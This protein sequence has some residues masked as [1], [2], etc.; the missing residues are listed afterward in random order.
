VGPPRLPRAAAMTHKIE[1]GGS[2]RESRERGHLRTAP[3]H[4]IDWTF[5]RFALV[6][7]AVMVAVA[8]IGARR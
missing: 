6:W 2:R 4:G 3:R 8:L 7:T 1:P 5:V